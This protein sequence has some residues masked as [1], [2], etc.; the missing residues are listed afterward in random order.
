MSRGA[1]WGVGG[2]QLQKKN[3]LSLWGRKYA[4]LGS[5]LPGKR[6]LVRTSGA[7]GQP[8]SAASKPLARASDKAPLTRAPLCVCIFFSLPLARGTGRPAASSPSPALRL[9]SRG[10]LPFPGCAPG[11]GD[12]FSAQRAGDP[13]RSGPSRRKACG[14]RA[15]AA[16]GAGGPEPST[17]EVP[18]RAGAGDRGARHEREA[19]VGG[20]KDP[21]SLVLGRERARGRGEGA[22]ARRAR[23]SASGAVTGTATGVKGAQLQEAGRLRRRS[24]RAPRRDPAPPRA[25]PAARARWNPHPRPEA[26]GLQEEEGAEGEAGSLLVLSGQA[27]SRKLSRKFIIRSVI[28]VEMIGDRGGGR[29]RSPRKI[30]GVFPPNR[31]LLQRE[32]PGPPIHR[33]AWRCLESWHSSRAPSSPRGQG[34]RLGHG[35]QTREGDPGSSPIC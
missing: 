24:V 2:R 26:P 31:R 13:S 19:G 18:P 9:P 15:G 17:P 8:R 4:L 35:A 34:E 25:P 5:E 28:S 14:G 1:R 7:P 10:G 16:R 29:L 30:K 33:P 20:R 32:H 27:G 23:G 22:R 6:P 11:P 3:L 12:A 21:S